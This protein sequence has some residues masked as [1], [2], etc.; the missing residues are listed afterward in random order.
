[1]KNTL[2]TFSKNFIF[3]LSANVISLLF[4][5]FLVFLL[6]RFLNLTNY[7]YWQLY[8]MYALY[9]GYLTF[10]ITDGIYLR[11]GGD[12]YDELPKDLFRSQFWFI[13]AGHIILDAFVLLAVVNTVADNNKQFIFLTMCLAGLLYVPKTLITFT[14]QATNRIKEYSIIIIFEKLFVL[15]LVVILTFLGS[16][17]YQ[18][19]VYA[20]LFGRLLTIVFS[21]FLAKD[22]VIGKLPKLSIAWR[23]TWQNITI[24]TKIL[25]AN[26]SSLLI[27]GIV[28]I[29]IEQRWGIELFGQIS[30]SFSVSNIITTL[31][32]SVSI[33]FFP[34]L[35]RMDE[36]EARRIY[37]SIRSV[38][39]IPLAGILAL[40][41]PIAL[42]LN[43]WLPSYT[44]SIK[45]L[46]LLFPI[47]L[48][49]SNMRLLINN[50][51][52]AMR[53]ER[54]LMI[55][56]ILAVLFTL[57]LSLLTTYLFNNL[58]LTVLVI[59]FVYAIRCILA[60][61]FVTKL[62]QLNTKLDILYDIA[63]AIIFTISAWNFDL[64]EG[65]AIYSIVYLAYVILKRNIIFNLV[66]SLKRSL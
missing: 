48:F 2:R 50:Y 7:A 25:I 4:N 54:F 5:T 30:F 41:F 22:I 28:R 14:M 33:V 10:G 59:L 11:Y 53:E 32:I 29:I 8:Q 16:R 27:N 38:L 57:I 35:K 65:F 36:E 3:T 44:L 52:K 18:I 17:N 55:I 24:G 56:N 60:E 51:L 45:Y 40:Y 23:E 26:L 58:I 64:L 66:R 39:M 1:M 46:A 49:E 20:D 63:L 34:L 37:T 43:N 13:I 62:L 15:A 31:I 21:A 6:P 42:I 19:F 12:D 47:T 9:I 61:L